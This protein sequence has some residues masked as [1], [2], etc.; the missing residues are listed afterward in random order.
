MWKIF[1]NKEENYLTVL[2]E[3]EN[4]KIELFNMIQNEIKQYFAKKVVTYFDNLLIF[5]QKQQKREVH[6]CLLDSLS[7][8]EKEM[9]DIG[10]LF[11]RIEIYLIKEDKG[12]DLISFGLEDRYIDSLQKY[13]FLI[14]KNN[15][16]VTDSK[17]ISL[18][19]ISWNS[20]VFD[21]DLI[22]YAINWIDWVPSLEERAKIQA[23]YLLMTS[24]CKSNLNLTMKE[25][26]EFEEK[27][28]NHPKYDEIYHKVYRLMPKIEIYLEEEWKNTVNTNKLN[29]N[30]GKI[31]K[32]KI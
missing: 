19:Q 32:T 25:K 10:G 16:K 5:Q 11:G 2:Q 29:S 22:N 14:V 15:V 31:K 9:Q 24:Y 26:I 6:I 1:F 30:F 28:E 18:K 12:V 7:Q 23:T 17:L 21:I 8:A 13:G 20:L 27:I 3:V 4:W